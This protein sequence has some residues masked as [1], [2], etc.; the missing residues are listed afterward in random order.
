MKDSEI[1]ERGAE[2]F[3]ALRSRRAVEPLTARHT[4]ID[5]N[6]AYR[7]STAFL[8][9]RLRE[10][11][12]VVG[13]KIGVT[14]KPVQRMLEVYQPDFGYLT[15]AMIVP[16]GEPAR[17]SE[18]CIQPRAEAEIAF[19]LRA[20][21]QGPG[22]TTAQALAAIEL[23]MPCFEIV[24]SRIKDW[25]IRI[26]DTVAD[27]ASC[28]L[29]VLGTQAVD[30]RSIDLGAVGCIVEKNGELLSTGAGAAALGSPINSIVWLANTLGRYGVPLRAGE[31]VL[32]GS[33]VPLEPV[34]TGDVVRTSID[35]IG[36]L[37]VRFT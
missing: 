31:I 37:T 21:L 28:G 18:L 1:A 32:S 7:I 22:V 13:K 11:E 10:G 24:D 4:G 27:N 16:A 5:V 29:V 20:D 2:L 36:S 26:E 6:D 8:D 35:R 17:I 34:K 9:A 14:S 3:A 30:P 12:R 19:V 25:K 33:L 23:A 15:D